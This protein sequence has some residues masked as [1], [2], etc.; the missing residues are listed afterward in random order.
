MGLPVHINV[1]YEAG[2]AVANSLMGVFLFA[3]LNRFKIRE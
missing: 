1:G 2:A 3:V